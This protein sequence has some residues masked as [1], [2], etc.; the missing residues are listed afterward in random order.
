LAWLLNLKRDAYLA[1]KHCVFNRVPQKII[2]LAKL[3][4]ADAMLIEGDSNDE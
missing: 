3:S 2:D 1:D 4:G